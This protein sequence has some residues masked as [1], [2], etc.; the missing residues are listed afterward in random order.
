MRRFA[1]LMATLSIAACGDDAQ[2]PTD[3]GFTSTGDSMTGASTEPTSSTTMMTASTTTSVSTSTTDPGTTES[4]GTTME[5]PTA[6][7]TMEPTEGTTME[8]PTEGTTMEEATTS[9]SGNEGTTMMET[10][11]DPLGSW[12]DCFAD[13]T[14]CLGG[15]TCIIAT[16]MDSL[17]GSFCAFTDCSDVGD[18][19]AAPATGTA[20]TTCEDAGTD[21]IAE[22]FLSCAAGETCPDGMECW[23]AIACVWPETDWTCPLSLYDQTGLAEACDCGC[24]L[25]DPDCDDMTIESC[26]MCDS[27]GS[28]SEEAC[29]GTID[30]LDNSICAI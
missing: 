6:G 3:D 21:G 2:E 13:D 17:Q 12:A 24:G 5:D 4:S 7:T 25:T 28:C 14:A 20:T 29:P 8:D 30:A 22:C 19:A 27:P 18:C 10:E 1:L 16:D 11:G 23:N 9:S 15:E 26:E